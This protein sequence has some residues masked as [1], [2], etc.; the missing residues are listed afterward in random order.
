MKRAGAKNA[1]DM[2]GIL[3]RI[4]PGLKIKVDGEDYA[5]GLVS[6]IDKAP[7]ASIG[8]AIATLQS[9]QGTGD[10]VVSPI[11]DD[12]GD[13]TAAIEIG[14]PDG[15]ESEDKE[16]SDAAEGSEPEDPADDGALTGDDAAAV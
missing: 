15:W 12:A 6:F 4:L 8:T 13:S 9:E 16:G 7:G 1:Q 10:P 3:E 11:R 2:I 14:A 5:G